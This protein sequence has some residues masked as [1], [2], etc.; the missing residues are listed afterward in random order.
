MT[1]TYQYKANTNET[2]IEKIVG[3]GEAG[4][5]EAGEGEA[6]EGEA[7][8]PDKVVEI[9]DQACVSNQTITSL[10]FSANSA[11]KKLGNQTFYDCSNLTTVIFPKNMTSIGN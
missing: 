5:G 2:I 9:M 7:I 6:G 10:I 1:I 4:E 8:I 11:C 3:S